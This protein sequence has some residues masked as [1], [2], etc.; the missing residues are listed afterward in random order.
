MYVPG[1][2]DRPPRNPAEKLNSGYKA[3]E[4][5]MYHYG[6]GP[7]MFYGIL[8][9]RYWKHFC[10]LVFGI[11]IFLQHKITKKQLQDGHTALLEYSHEFELLYYQRRADRLHFV[12]QSLHNL[13]HL[14][15]ETVCLG[16]G[17]YHSQWT[18]EW[19]IGNLGEEVKLHSNPYMN[20]SKRAICCAQVN[21]LK[22]MVPELD[23][24]SKNKLPRNAIDLGDGFIVLGAIDTCARSVR[25]V[26]SEALR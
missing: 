20:L 1:S 21:A 22:A 15:P 7:P 17:A 2:F 18:M 26:E 6:L 25:R 11:R 5:L 12:L 3:W 14:G 4:H 8:P 19:T 9:D 23:T 10:K 24:N 16:P 13:L